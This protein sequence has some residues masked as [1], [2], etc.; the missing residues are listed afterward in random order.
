MHLKHPKGYEF[1]RDHRSFNSLLVHPIAIRQIQ[2]FL[3][4]EPPRDVVVGSSMHQHY[5]LWICL[6]G[7]GCLMVDGIPYVFREKNAIVT[8]P[9][10]Q[11]QRL[12]LGKEQI[13][14]L[15]IR[16]SADCPGWFSMFR[17][18]VIHLSGKSIGY[19]RFFSRHYLS[20]AEEHLPDAALECS[21]FLGLL[22]NSLRTAPELSETAVRQSMTG[23]EYVRQA[24][25]LIISPEFTGKSYRQVAREIGISPAYLRELFKKNIGLTPAQLIKSHQH[26]TIQYLLLNSP[27]NITQIA[28]KCGYDTVY[29]FSRY[30]RKTTGI[31]PREFRK[32]Y[33]HTQDFQ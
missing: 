32:K 31:S 13:D 7:K 28:E 3:R 17:N 2:A 30:F 16:F 8:F 23:N 10:Q 18:R 21:Y 9:A 11:H 26:K 19:L 29:S 5:V 6:R 14:W 33:R 20:A 12:A 22:L 27:L 15:L 24:S 4:H 25:R 1:G